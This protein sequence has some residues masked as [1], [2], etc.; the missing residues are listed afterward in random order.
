MGAGVKV[1]YG[2][3]LGAPVSVGAGVGDA[4]LDATALGLGDGLT[5]S[6]PASP[7]ASDEPTAG[8]VA[9]GPLSDE[10]F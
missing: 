5:C 7:G 6:E 8:G 4:G 2:V 3:K 10:L 1:G 9:P